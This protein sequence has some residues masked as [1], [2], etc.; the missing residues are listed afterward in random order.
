M[1]IR[2]DIQQGSDE[3]HNLRIGK[4]TGS[5]FSKLLGTAAAKEKYLYDKANEIVTRCKS[6]GDS[7]NNVHMQRGSNFESV[8]RTR[9]LL[10]TFSIVKEVGIVIVDDYLACSPDGLIDE[11]GLIEI[12]VPDSNNY[13]RQLL[14][15]SSEGLKVIPN[16]YYIQMQF[17][18]Y[19]CGRNWC[20]YVLYNPQHAINDREMFI[21]RVPR[22][23]EM[24]KKI[25]QVLDESIIKIKQ[26]VDQ[27]FVLCK[28]KEKEAA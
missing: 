12:K 14:Q 20:D 24:Q 16:D 8:A 4:I 19:V 26:Y 25:G 17:N 28:K 9:Y 15:I 7:F 21:Y 13:F 6:D 27:Y 5:S 1:I 11:D 18:M 22:D 2:T 10:E 23:D 3:W